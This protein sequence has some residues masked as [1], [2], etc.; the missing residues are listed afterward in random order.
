MLLPRFYTD[1]EKFLEPGKVLVVYGPRRVGKTTLIQHYLERTKWNYKL[2]S[3]DNIRT[4]H[5]L[6]SQD[7]SQILPYAENYDLL[8]I[9]EAQ[10]IP[11]IGMAFKIL[12]DQKPS[13]RIIATGSSSFELA[14]QVGEPL[15]GRKKTVT[16]YPIAQQELLQ[17]QFNQFELKEKLAEYLVFGSYPEIVTASSH[18]EK[19]ALLEELVSSYLLK[20]ILTLENVKGSKILLS[21]LKLLAF[22]VGN[23]VSL[24]EI[25]N[26]VNIDVKTVARYLDLLEK[27]FVIQ[28]LS[29]YSRNLRSEI[30]SKAKYYFLDTGIRNGIIQQYQGLESRNDIGQLWENFIFIERLKHRQFASLYTNMYFWRTYNQQEIDIVEERNGKLYG[31][32]CKWSEKSRTRTPREW[33]TTYPESSYTTITPKNYMEFIS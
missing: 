23:Q 8:V 32:E 28:S 5:T 29:G 19:I 13:L 26:S 2:D 22:Q 9:D 3:G 30:T 27:G 16:L 31:Y 14:G 11:H 33:K 24:N 17:T 1:L 12:V 15:T 18:K 21:V 25:A 6:S 20:D 7:F 10:N 4:Q